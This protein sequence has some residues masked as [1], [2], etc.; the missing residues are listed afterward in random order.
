MWYRPQAEVTQETM[1]K[2]SSTSRWPTR[3]EIEIILFELANLHDQGIN[4]FR[5][6]AASFVWR[7]ND[8]EVMRFRDELRQVWNPA[9]AKSEKKE[10]IDGWLAWQPRGLASVGFQPWQANLELRRVLPHPESF[11]ALLALGVLDNFDRLRICNNPD[12]AAAYFIAKRSDQRY[13]ERGE[14]TRYA[15]RLYSRKEYRARGRARRRQR[16]KRLPKSGRT[17]P[18][19]RI[20]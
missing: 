18:R 4:D 20:R 8:H 6:R 5:P 3:K 17:K 11:G 7:L 15:Q 13:C 14:C 2:T 19:K 10:L 9:I 12:C 16:L 1:P